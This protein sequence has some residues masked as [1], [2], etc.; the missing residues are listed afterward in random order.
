MNK[1][2]LIIEKITGSL[3]ATWGMIV[4]YNTTRVVLESIN[5]GQVPPPNL[6]YMRV[7]KM[8]HLY[9][10]LALATMFAGTLMV[11]NDK[12]GWLLSIIC[13]VMYAI[14]FFMSAR[15]NSK[16]TT[17]PYFQFF[18]SYALMVLPFLAITILL[19]QKPFRQ[20]YQVT[21]KNW[22]WVIAII[23]VLIIDKIIF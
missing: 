6:S 13:T 8:N 10:L 14:A 4:L 1:N 17:Q 16:A 5:Y 3:L 19:I 7:F 15:F 12:Q 2:W 22:I 23:I 11:F 18:K 21:A 20:K 9:F